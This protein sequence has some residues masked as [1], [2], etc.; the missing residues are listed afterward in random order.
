MPDATTRTAR[1]A[2]EQ[3]EQQDTTSL[4]DT[5]CAQ[6]EL[7]GIGLDVSCLGLLKW[8]HLMNSTTTTAA[9]ITTT[10]NNNNNNSTNNNNHNIH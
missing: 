3:K 9:T 4:E 5:K 6:E 7:L 10:K 1:T 8:S 2:N